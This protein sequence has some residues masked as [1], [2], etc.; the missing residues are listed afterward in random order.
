ML[1]EILPIYHFIFL[2]AGF[3]LKKRDYIKQFKTYNI[4][5]NHCAKRRIRIKERILLKK[6]YLALDKN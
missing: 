1:Y 6:I 5:E 3:L 4:Y 2:S